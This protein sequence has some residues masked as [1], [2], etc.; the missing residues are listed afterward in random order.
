MKPII[1]F[2]LT[3]V[4]ITIVLLL[5]FWVVVC[6]PEPWQDDPWTPW[7]LAAGWAVRI[8]AWPVGLVAAW[9]DPTEWSVVPDNLVTPVFV[10]LFA[11]SGAFWAAILQM[12]WKLKR[13][14]SQNQQVDHISNSANAV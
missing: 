8:L 4:M 6:A 11:V 10:A 3:A 14:K 13:R 7:E 9:L 2:L 12:L 5:L 1:T